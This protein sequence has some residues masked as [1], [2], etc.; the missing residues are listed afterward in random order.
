M[1]T[2]ETCTFNHTSYSQSI[3]SVGIEAERIKNQEGIYRGN[4]IM[5]KQFVMKRVSRKFSW[6]LWFSQKSSIANFLSDFIL[7]ADKTEYFPVQYARIFECQDR[8]LLL[9]QL[10]RISFDTCVVVVSRTPTVTQFFVFNVFSWAHSCLENSITH[11]Q[12]AKIKSIKISS[13][14]I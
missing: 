10:K 8:F 12:E 3:R 11:V 13:D 5:K 9:E 2:I 4:I 7:F 14:A 1:E 6:F